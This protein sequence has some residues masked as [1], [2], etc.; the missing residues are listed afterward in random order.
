MTAGF[1]NA[2]ATFAGRHEKGIG[3][4]ENPFH[5]FNTCERVMSI[6]WR[7]FDVSVPLGSVVL[8]RMTVVRNGAAD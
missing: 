8:G 6:G 3:F 5:I 1:C 2:D 7:L 4:Q